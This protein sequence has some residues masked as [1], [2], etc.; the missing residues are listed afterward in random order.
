MRS[1]IA[2]PGIG[3]RR[4]LFFLLFP[5]SFFLF[6]LHERAFA[7]ISGKRIAVLAF[8]PVFL[9]SYDGLRD[10]LAALGCRP[11]QDINFKVYSLD[12]DMRR[13]ALVMNEIL[14]WDCDLIY[15]VTT[16]VT[17][18]V[19]RYL[20]SAG[21]EKP[22]VFTAVADPVGSGAVADLRRPASNLT[23]VSHLSLELLPQRLLF[24]KKAFP[25]LRRVAIFYDADEEIS[26]TS[27]HDEDF[28]QAALDCRIELAA[29]PVHNLQELHEAFRGSAVQAAEGIFMLPDALGVAFFKELLE[30]SRRRRI[31][32][33]V[34]DNM[35]LEIGGV[36]GYS[37]DFYGVGQQAA[38][39]VDYILQGGAPGEIPVQN[40]DRVKLVVSLRELQALG[41]AV[42]E[43]ILLQADEVL[44]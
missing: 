22:V 10:G 3:S 20:K 9:Q 30:F 2:R 37:P 36:M 43:E 28:R 16:S 44:R 1:F 21:S 8:A 42:N 4:F 31:P 12:H 41:L 32:L 15:T 27:F 6:F 11:G 19:K 34:V 17:M 38:I 14:L 13:L 18:G 7:E 24:F 26:L 5:L 25:S 40:P 35:L 29:C 33:M 23:G 39:M